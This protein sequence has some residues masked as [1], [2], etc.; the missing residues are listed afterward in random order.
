MLLDKGGSGGGGIKCGCMKHNAL[1][2]GSVG[3]IDGYKL[4]GHQLMRP[5]IRHL[6]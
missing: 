2:V 1:N 5:P 6:I 4:G 3:P